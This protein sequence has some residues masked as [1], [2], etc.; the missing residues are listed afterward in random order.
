M[1][2]RLDYAMKTDNTFGLSNERK[3]ARFAATMLA[4]SSRPLIVP[5]ATVKLHTKRKMTSACYT[6]YSKWNEQY[7]RA[8]GVSMPCNVNCQEI[9]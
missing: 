5:T 6:N 7:D 4:Y 3:I 1:K 2:S 8:T 9:G